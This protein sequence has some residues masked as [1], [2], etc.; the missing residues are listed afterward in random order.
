MRKK[1]CKFW[2]KRIDIQQRKED[3]GNTINALNNKM[4]KIQFDY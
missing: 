4:R 3:I 2:N 1:K